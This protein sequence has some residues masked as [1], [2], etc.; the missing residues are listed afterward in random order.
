MWAFAGRARQRAKAPATATK[1]AQAASERARKFA[2][3]SFWLG[4]ASYVVFAIA[5]AVSAVFLYAYGRA[6]P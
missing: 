5:L 4:I 2:W 6:Q 1:A 3:L